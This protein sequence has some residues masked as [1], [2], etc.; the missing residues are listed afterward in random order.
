[1]RFIGP[2]N[3]GSSLETIAQALSIQTQETIHFEFEK[4]GLNEDENFKEPSSSIAQKFSSIVFELS[5][6]EDPSLIPYDRN[7]VVL[8]KP[9]KG[10]DYINATWINRPA[11]EG[12]YTL[13][14]MSRYTKST[15][16]N[17]IVAQNPMAHTMNHYYQMLHENN[18][19]MIVNV[20]NRDDLEDIK[21]FEGCI[22]EAVDLAGDTDIKISEGKY[23]TP[24]LV[25][26]DVQFLSS[27]LRKD[28]RLQHQHPS[29][30]HRLGLLPV[31]KLRFLHVIQWPKSSVSMAHSMEEQKDLLSSITLV[32]QLLHKIQGTPSLVVQDEEAGVE[33]AA[34][35][36]ALLELMENVDDL[37]ENANVD[38]EIESEVS[39]YINPF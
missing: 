38:G 31:H 7:R 13:P 17:V 8:C 34:L 25:Q 4:L 16:M 20:C 5:L 9:I 14:I 29:D 6:N 15:H 18:I 11:G 21:H 37:V 33:G 2:K 3:E 1:M 36:L 23:I 39:S 27:K 22:Y 19:D 30:L 24:F 35:F 32:R 26:Q 28:P 12:A 10:V